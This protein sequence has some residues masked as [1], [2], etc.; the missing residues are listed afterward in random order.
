M[1]PLRVALV[2]PYSWPDVR[3]GGERYLADLAWYLAEAGH[4]VDVVTGTEASATDERVD[5]VMVRRRHHILR[6]RLASRGIGSTETFAVPAL[7]CLLRRRYDVVHALTPTAAI[8]ARLAGQR[9]VFTLLGHPTDDALRQ[10]PAPARLLKI[11]ARK[12]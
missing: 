7:S 4:L 1:R 10:R 9:T 5:G 6:H 2:H 11:G 12:R 8:T 3:R